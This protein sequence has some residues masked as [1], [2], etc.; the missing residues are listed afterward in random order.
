MPD[1]PFDVVLLDADE[2]IFDFLK[3]EK[4]SVLKTAS[5]FGITADDSD[6]EFYSSINL[7]FWKQLELGAITREELKVLR[8]VKW[9]EYL[10]IHNAEPIAFSKAYE[11]NFSQTGILFDGAEEFVRTLSE[12]CSVYIV[13]NGPSKCQHGRMDNSSISKYISGMFI[14]EEVGYTKPDKRFFDKVF[15]T[16]DINDRSKVIIIGDSLTSDMLG[17]RNAGIATCRYLPTGDTKKDPLCDYQISEYNQF[18]DI[19]R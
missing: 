4:L 7:S 6:A 5:S 16:L 2:T 9:F 18:F 10:D 1:F 12:L 19:F 13:T 14:S 17:G 15:D 8:F 3:A 11:D